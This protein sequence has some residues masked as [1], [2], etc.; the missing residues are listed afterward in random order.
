MPGAPGTQQIFTLPSS[1]FDSQTRW[2]R[3]IVTQLIQFDGE[4]G[5]DAR[6]A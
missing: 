3:V 4:R 1:V 6:A 2:R 5:G